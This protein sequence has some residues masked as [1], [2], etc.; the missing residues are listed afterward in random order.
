[1]GQFLLERG[2]QVAER[3]VAQPVHVE[4]QIV[5]VDP[6]G[7]MQ[8]SGGRASGGR[9]VARQRFV[10]MLIP[11]PVELPAHGAHEGRRDVADGVVGVVGV[12]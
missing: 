11:G 2:S 7:S 5:E 6:L 1:M 8:G 4:E 10:V 9:G 12:D 3:G